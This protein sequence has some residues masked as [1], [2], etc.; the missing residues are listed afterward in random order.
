MFQ[1]FGVALARH[2]VARPI[3]DGLTSRQMLNHRESRDGSDYEV[4]ASGQR[5][6][7][8]SRSGV[9]DETVSEVNGRPRH[10]RNHS[11]ASKAGTI[12]TCTKLPGRLA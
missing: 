10:L 9:P 5:V 12:F 2:E 4:D 7:H 8:D 1:Q 6:G 3:R 11:A